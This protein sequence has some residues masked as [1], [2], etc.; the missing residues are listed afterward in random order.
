MNNLLKSLHLERMARR[1]G[2]NIPSSSSPTMIGPTT[3]S[4]AAA[5]AVAVG[6]TTDRKRT[7]AEAI[8]LVDDNDDS[9]EKEMLRGPDKKRRQ[10]QIES[11]AALARRLS[12]QHD[13][14]QVIPHAALSTSSDND[15][16]DEG[17]HEL[18]S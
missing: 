14:Q 3:T 6:S 11:D 9:D 16:N 7:K 1:G 17:F 4:T 8:D 13:N 10:N 2:G 12:L 5:A 15:S 18:A